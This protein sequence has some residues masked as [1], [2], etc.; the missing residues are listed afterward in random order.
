MEIVMLN[1]VKS[2]GQKCLKLG[3]GIFMSGPKL[4]PGMEVSKNQSCLE[5][6]ET[7][8]GLGFWKFNEILKMGIFLNCPQAAIQTPWHP[9]G[10]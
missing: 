10:T 5:C 6:P 3:S 8:F 7:H 4:S 2:T 1:E 9:A